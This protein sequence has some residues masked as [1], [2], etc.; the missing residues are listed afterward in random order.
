MRMSQG[1]EDDQQAGAGRGDAG[2][3]GARG[4]ETGAPGGGAGPNAPSGAG[5]MRLRRYVVTEQQ[6]VTMPVT[7]EEYRLE[8]EDGDEGNAQR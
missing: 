8:P 3:V 7:R 4:G 2:T 5:H 6:T 1:P